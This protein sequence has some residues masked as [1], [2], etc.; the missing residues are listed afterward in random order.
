MDI[1]EDSPDEDDRR[2]LEALQNHDG[3][4]RMDDKG[5]CPLY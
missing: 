3:M 5:M 1:D 4:D 2:A